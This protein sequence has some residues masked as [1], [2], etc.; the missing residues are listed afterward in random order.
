VQ[1][2]DGVPGFD[3]VEAEGQREATGQLFD[4]AERGGGAIEAVTQFRQ[5][6]VEKLAGRGKKNYFLKSVKKNEQTG[7][8]RRN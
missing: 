6:L 8:C 4:S 2:G 1:H 5:H 7:N 3:L